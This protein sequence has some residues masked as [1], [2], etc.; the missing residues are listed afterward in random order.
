MFRIQCPR[1][2][3]NLSSPSA[4]TQGRLRC[5][6][7]NEVIAVP[8]P[9]EGQRRFPLGI[10]GIGWG[11]IIGQ[12]V[13]VLVL[14]IFLIVGR[15]SATEPKLANVPIESRPDPV[16]DIPPRIVPPEV[17]L[18]TI[19]V[20]EPVAEKEK[21]PPAQNP[22]AIKESAP[23]KKT[24]AKAEID[25]AWVNGL[26]PAKFSIG[27]LG[28]LDLRISDSPKTKKDSGFLPA[29]YRVELILDANEIVV[30]PMRQ[31][32]TAYAFIVRMSTAGLA[33]KRVMRLPGVWSVVETKKL[34][35]RTFYV[36]E[37]VDG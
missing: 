7:C 17:P 15:P 11:I 16:S 30:I 21:I 25:K 33:E 34:T 31:N 13:L 4:P 18:K 36:L 5:P 29:D 27:D 20:S 24:F 1:C 8:P 22:P 14:F 3:S 26:N 9:V 28:R 10:P 35:S 2:Q 19:E 23:P 32:W 12:A 6:K 37:K